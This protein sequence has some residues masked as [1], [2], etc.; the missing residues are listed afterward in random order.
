MPM[1]YCAQLP[2]PTLD[3]IETLLVTVVAYD[4]N[5]LFVVYF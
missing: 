4:Y 3:V 1:K 2:R 5:Y